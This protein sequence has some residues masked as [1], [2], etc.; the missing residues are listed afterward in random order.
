MIIKLY[1]PETLEYENT[2]S[3]YESVQW[4]TTYNTSE[5]EFQINCA[6][7]YATILTD[8]WIVENSEDSEHFGV[9]KSIQTT[10]SNTRESLVVKGIMFFTKE[11]QKA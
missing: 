5:G 7:D 2:L 3:L 9:I 6:V 10:K 4:I 8:G 1:D 11:S